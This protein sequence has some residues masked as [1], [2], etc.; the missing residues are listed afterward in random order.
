MILFFTSFYT[1]ACILHSLSGTFNNY[2][3]FQCFEPDNNYNNR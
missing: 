2:G 3:L 1:S